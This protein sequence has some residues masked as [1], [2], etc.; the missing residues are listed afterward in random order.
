[1]MAMS[2]EGPGMPQ[3]PGEQ[4]TATAA[5]GTPGAAAQ[6]RAGT[7]RSPATPRR[8]EQ[9][10]LATAY[11]LGRRAV[12]TSETWTLAAL[13]ILLVIFTSLAPGTFLTLSNLS[14]VAK[15]AAP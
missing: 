8:E 10:A 15:D 12:T 9:R 3:S 13:I 11:Q 5:S 4:D 7:S 6:A 1:M 2:A 14:S